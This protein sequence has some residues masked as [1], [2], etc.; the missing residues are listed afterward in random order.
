MGKQTWK[1]M[2]A[3]AYSPCGGF[4]TSG[5]LW[6]LLEGASWTTRLGEF[7]R[8]EVEGH[9]VGP[10]HRVQAGGLPV[11]KKKPLGAQCS[12]IVIDGGF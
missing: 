2:E 5:D 11:Q 8:H 10:R 9:R 3:D 4:S 7:A 12:H 1:D 6:D